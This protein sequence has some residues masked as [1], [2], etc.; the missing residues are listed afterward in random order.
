MCIPRGCWWWWPIF[1]LD[2]R[3]G[4]Y[5]NF[6]CNLGPLPILTFIAGGSLCLAVKWSV[7]SQI[8]LYI[9]WPRNQ[10]TLEWNK[11]D[12]RQT[13]YEV[14]H[15]LTHYSSLV[16]SISCNNKSQPIMT[17]N[18]CC[19]RDNMS[20][21]FLSRWLSSHPSYSRMPTKKT[22]LLGS[23]CGSFGRA[24]ASNTRDPRFESRH[25]QTFIVHLFTVNCVEKTKN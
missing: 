5:R 7:I 10:F 16:Y 4:C 21:L 20:S 14:D 15:S 19:K 24:V 11:Q 25:W 6:H 3:Q 12:H 13:C 2:H 23:G 17:K 1:C 9:S 18:W 22:C 8:L